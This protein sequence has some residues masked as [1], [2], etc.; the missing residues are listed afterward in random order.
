LDKEQYRSIIEIYFESFRTGEFSRVPF[1]S[2]IQFPS[3]I[4][5]ITM[6]SRDEV[7]RRASPT[8]PD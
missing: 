4:S 7:V 5:G 2:Q 3:P 6:K 8:R 1:S